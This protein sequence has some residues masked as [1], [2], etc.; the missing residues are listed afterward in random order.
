MS[1]T[2]WLGNTNPP[3]VSPS[4]LDNLSNAFSN[5]LVGGLMGLTQGFAQAAMPSRMPI[6]FGAALG[7]AAGGMQSGMRNAYATRL[8]EQQ[9]EAARIANQR[10]NLLFQR[11]GQQFGGASGTTPLSSSSVG[12]AAP[13]GVPG[14][15]GAGTDA[16]GNYLISPADL[17]ARGDL[18]MMTGQDRAAAQLYGMPNTIA[19]GAGYFMTPNGVASFTPGG[20]H[21]PRVM[22]RNVLATEIPKANISLQEKYLTPGTQPGEVYATPSQTLGGIPQVGGGGVMPQASGGQPINPAVAALTTVPEP[23]R[24]P[25][26]NAMLSSGMPPAAWPWFVSTIHR[27]S[28]WNPAV[29]IGA[30]GEI[31]LGQVKPATGQMLG[32]T[33]QQL[34]DPSQNLQAAA[35]Y[36]SQQWQASGGDPMKTLAGYNAGDI[37]KQVNPEYAGP[38]QARVQQWS[39]AAPNAVAP[40]VVQRR[41]PSGS[42]V[43]TNTIPVQTKLFESDMADLQ[44]ATE[45]ATH[46][47]QNM[48]RLYDMRD[49]AKQLT[50][51]GFGGESRAA[52]SNF[53][54]TYIKPIPGMG[55]AASKFLQTVG[56]LPPAQQ[57]QEFAKLNLQAAGMQERDAV[58]ARGGYRLTELY[59]RANPSIGLQPGANVDIANLQLV[60]HQMDLDYLRGL[61]DHVMAN[62]QAFST[63]QANYVPAAQFDKQWVEQDNPKIYLAATYALNGKPFAE[64]AKLIGG[65]KDPAK[66][67]AAIDVVRRVDP[68][69]QIMWQDGKPHMFAGQ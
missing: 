23:L 8:A 13:M 19:G 68:T 7:L 5:P 28:Q 40:G 58:G 11:F 39:G 36:F 31:G 65:D 15:P 20:P 1:D 43:T 34:A 66:L 27:E 41:T 24:V 18:A 21:D 53:V 44:K 30:A 10:A 46:I 60:A 50:Q 45:D 16:N 56:N 67:K 37:N 6:P 62:G 26:V 17:V 38:I 32:F 51:S 3:A 22:S 25:A 54:E 29:P 49:L 52:V 69:A 64:W 14:T 9:A 2:S 59:Q 47:Q 61:H 12:G 63:G 35:K 48:T 55:D 42:V 57:A 33:P 4:W